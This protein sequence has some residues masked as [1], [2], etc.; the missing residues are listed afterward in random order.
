MANEN[1]TKG[2][3]VSLKNVRWLRIDEI[4]ELWAPEIGVAPSII[5]RELQLAL[6][7]LP[8]LAEGT[9]LIDAF[10]E[11]ELPPTD[12]IMDQEQIYAFCEKEGHWPRPEFW[13]G[14]QQRGPRSLAVPP[15]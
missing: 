15:L 14:E 7:N 2:P 12:S 13:F 3:V 5:K 10:P 4:A 11:T 1:T 9:G 8:R 6:I